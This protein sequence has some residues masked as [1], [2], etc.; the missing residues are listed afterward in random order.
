MAF[1]I[2]L[3]WL[4][5][6]TA[7]RAGVLTLALALS[8]AS[9]HRT[10][11][12]LAKAFMGTFAFGEHEML[13]MISAPGD[14]F[15][16]KFSAGRDHLFYNLEMTKVGD[17]INEMARQVG[18]GEKYLGASVATFFDNS[19]LRTFRPDFSG[20]TVH[21]TE[22][23]RIDFSGFRRGTPAPFGGEFHFVA[24]PMAFDKS[25]LDRLRACCRE[26]GN[27]VIEVDGYALTVYH[28]S[29]ESPE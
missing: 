24:L 2:S 14:T 26:T 9:M 28:F 20:R 1:V 15:Q 11:D 3:R 10:I 19:D 4:V 6:N 22:R 21:P 12:P 7:A 17:L 25:G 13:V 23:V 27:R 16:R 5:S 18:P 8:V 29:A